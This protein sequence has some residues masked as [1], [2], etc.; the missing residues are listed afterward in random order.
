MLTWDRGRP[1][2]M[3]SSGRDARAPRS[4]TVAGYRRNAG[5]IQIMIAPV[6]FRGSITQRPA[7]RLDQTETAITRWVRDQSRWELRTRSH[8]GG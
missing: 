4:I 1:A 8:E 2:R 5:S 3:D 7:D 6:V